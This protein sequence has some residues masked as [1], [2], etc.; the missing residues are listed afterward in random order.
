[1]MNLI[2]MSSRAHDYE[3]LLEEVI[4]AAFAYTQTDVNKTL[5]VVI[6]DD[7]TIKSM[8]KQYRNKDYVTDVLTFPS[9][10]AEELGDVVIALDKATVQ[11]KAYG[12]SVEREIAFL[13]V[14][15]FLHAIGYDHANEKSAQ[16]MNTLQEAI[17]KHCGLVREK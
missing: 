17:L 7:A 12:H 6:V 10:E 8:N 5:S 4:K 16:V 11:A 2:D 14:H 13:A 1:M 9:D 15:G 3:A